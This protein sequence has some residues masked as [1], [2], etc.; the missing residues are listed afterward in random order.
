M[1]QQPDLGAH[2]RPRRGGVRGDGTRIMLGVW[3]VTLNPW[4]LAAEQ[5]IQHNTRR[6][7]VDLLT[8]G[9]AIADLK[10]VYSLKVCWGRVET[11][12]GYKSVFGYF[13]STWE[14]Q[15]ESA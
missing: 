10:G 14:K 4:R 1:Q 6:P 5:D 13:H 7:E 9:L 3:R 15:T 12:L 2:M 8:V 11:L